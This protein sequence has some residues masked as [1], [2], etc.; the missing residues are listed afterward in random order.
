MKIFL[1]E[2]KKEGVSN[3]IELITEQSVL[4]LELSA[5]GMYMYVCMYVQKWKNANKQKAQ[6]ITWNN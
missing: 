3:K 5:S 4:V 1:E 6:L 2:K